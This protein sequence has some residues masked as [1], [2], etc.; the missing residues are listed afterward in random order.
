M[1]ETHIK[2]IQMAGRTNCKNW[3]QMM[4]T[5]EEY[6]NLLLKNVHYKNKM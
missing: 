4:A 6:R 1:K 3:E 2:F 5:L